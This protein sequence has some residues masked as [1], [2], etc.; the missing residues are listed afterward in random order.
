MSRDHATQF[1]EPSKRLPNLT[2]HVGGAAL[3]FVAMGI[4]VSAGV[5]AGAGGS[6]T[7]AML[8]AAGIVAVVGVTMWSLTTI[9][10]R[11]SASAT[12]VAVG[13]TWALAS[14]AGAVPYVL[15]GTFPTIDAALFESVSGFTGTGSSVLAPIE[16]APRGILFW[17]S[18]TQWYGG[19]GMVVLA[20]AILPF[21]GVGGME[22]LRAEA[23]GPTADRL[24][25]R[26]S[27]TAKR[28]WLVY[29]SFTIVSMAVLLVIGL[30][31][32]DA[33]THAFTVV[34]TG[35]LSPYDA[36][37]GHFDSLLVELTLVGLMLFGA[38][39]FSLHWRA[40]SGTPSSYLRSPMF[41]YYVT[42]FASFVA[43]I[44]TLLWAQQGQPLHQALRDAV[45]NVTTLLT[46][47]GY[48]T[49]DYTQWAPAIQLLL[50]ALMISGGMAGST[51]GGLKLVR[52]RVLTAHAIREVQRIRRPSAVLPV[53]LGRDAV[54]E[55]IVERVVGYS[56]LYVLLI[57]G[58]TLVLTF[59]GA[60]LLEA[61]GGAASVMGNMG[62]A[63][64]E[65]GP[66]SNFLYFSRPARAVLMVMMLA[67][68]LEIF[69]V[70]FLLTT[71]FGPARPLQRRW[72]SAARRSVRRSTRPL[73]RMDR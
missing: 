33:T 38:V 64:G 66:A 25:P 23:P 53:R 32:F 68:R 63:L 61:A 34:S 69:P 59:L 22:L 17:R 54:Q 31:P 40:F 71:L 28:L 8:V 72:T 11:T 29:G 65:A 16:Q 46:S 37:I 55:R 7:G 67:G 43:L 50:F 70:M 52:V 73:A 5:E 56:L 35:G 51:S 24:A 27:E 47:T 20:V 6:E 44:T 57:G 10:D 14:M 18:L 49:V 26:V 30:S 60:G 48:A 41:R 13:A 62:P 36:S 15:A 45:F 12:L 9:P 39:N 3:V 42:V 4:L 21:L 19:T 58:G 2:A 1:R